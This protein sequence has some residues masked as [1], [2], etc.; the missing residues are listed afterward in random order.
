MDEN[1]KVGD[2]I[3]TNN[4]L[5]FTSAIRYHKDKWNGALTANYLGYRYNS[6]DDG[7]THVKPA[8]YTDLDI[9]YAPGAQHKVF[10]HVNNLFGREDYTTVT[11]PSDATFAYI[12]Q[13]RNYMLGYEYKF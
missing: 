12:S 3:H 8:L 10:L 1:F 6:A 7:K 11:A 13:G 9:S 2:W 4:R 5:Q